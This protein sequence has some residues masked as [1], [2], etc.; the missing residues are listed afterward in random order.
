VAARHSFFHPDLKS[1][2]QLDNCSVESDEP[3]PRGW[4]VVTS[5]GRQIGTVI[6]LLIEETDHENA[7]PHVRYL[8][9]D[10]DGGAL[11]G[12]SSSGSTGLVRVEDIDLDGGSQRVTA[13]AIACRDIHRVQTGVTAPAADPTP[14][15]T[16]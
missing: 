2:S 16:V 10:I 7:A 5:S 4:T 3:D 13:R 1:L 9:I 6:D 11:P 8:V 15:T 12:I 14:A